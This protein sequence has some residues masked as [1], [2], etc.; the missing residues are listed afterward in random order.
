MIWLHKPQ[1]R[2]QGFSHPLMLSDP[3][4]Y[5]GRRLQAVLQVFAR[6]I[7]SEEGE[8]RQLRL[9]HANPL[10]QCVEEL[11]H[12]SGAVKA[13]HLQLVRAQSKNGLNPTDKESN[14]SHLDG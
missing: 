1:S 6:R 7:V 8:P 9:P 5:L 4:L 3:Q 13:H 14:S 10:V 11:F 12:C 2:V